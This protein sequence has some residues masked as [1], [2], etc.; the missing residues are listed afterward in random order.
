MNDRNSQAKLIEK[1]TIKWWAQMQDFVWRITLKKQV[2]SSKESFLWALGTI[3]NKNDSH[4]VVPEHKIQC[5][6][7]LSTAKHVLKV[8]RQ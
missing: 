8:L 7:N 6:W 1:T 3:Y 5:P 4:L 2:Y